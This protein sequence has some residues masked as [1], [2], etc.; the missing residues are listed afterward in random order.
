MP[1]DDQH[2]LCDW[3][4]VTGGR[5]RVVSTTCQPLFP[6]LEAGT[7]AEALYYRLNVLCFQLTEFES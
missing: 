4:A 6:L 5:T 3:L 1:R 7:F 2:G